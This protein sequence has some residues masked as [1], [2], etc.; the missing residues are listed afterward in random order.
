MPRGRDKKYEDKR[1]WV[2]YNERLVKRG[3][4]YLSLDFLETWD[5]EVCRMNRGKRGRPF[6]YPDTFI[7]FAAVLYHCFSLPYRQLEG[8]LRSLFRYI[9][10]AKSPD[11]TTLFRRTSMLDIHVNLTDIEGDV[12]VAVDST[13]IKVTNRGE[14]LRHKWKVKRGWIKLHVA[15]DVKNGKIISHHI[16][17]EKVGDNAMFKPLIM[18][19]ERNTG[20]K[21]RIKRVY[22]DGAYDTRL[23]FNLMEKMDIQPGIKIRKTASTRSHGSPYRA[24]CVREYKKLG[25]EKWKEKTGYGKRWRAE[26]T[27]SALKRIFGEEVRASSTEQMFREVEMRIMLYNLLLDI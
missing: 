17:T 26:S 7:Q 11:Y 21:K 19:A 9:K 27:F 18:D 15:V 5:S 13:G 6:E 14:W 25:Y 23:A 3:E 10:T 8:V 4:F 22:G 24:K 16:T 1:N 12:V 20:G 2:E